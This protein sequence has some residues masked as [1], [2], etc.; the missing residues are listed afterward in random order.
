VAAPPTAGDESITVDDEG[1]F[2]GIPDGDIGDV[3]GEDI[4]K[5]GILP[6]T[7]GTFPIASYD[8]AVMDLQTDTIGQEDV[9]YHWNSTTNKLTAEI[10]SGSRI[11]QTLFQLQVNPTTGAYT[12]LLLLPVMHEVV[13]GENDATANLTFTVTDNDGTSDTGT[14]AITLNDDMPVD[15]AATPAILANTGGAIGS[16][17]LNF[18]GNSGADLPADVKFDSGLDGAAL[19]NAGGL[20]NLTYNGEDIIL[21]ID[22]TG[23][24]LTGVSAISSTLVLTVTLNPDA[25]SEGN[26]QYTIELH[27]LID[28]GSI[29]LGDVINATVGGGFSPWIA[30]NGAQDFDLLMYGFE[31]SGGSYLADS[32]NTNNG[33]VG[34]D[35]GQ[36]LYTNEGVRFDL[37]KSVV[38]VP[39]GN[40]QSIPASSTATGGDTFVHYTATSFTFAVDAGGGRDPDVSISLWRAD[41]D[42]TTYNDPDDVSVA[43]SRVEVNGVDV[44]TAYFTNGG[45]LIDLNDDDVVTVYTNDPAG[46]NAIEVINND[47]DGGTAQSDSFALYGFKAGGEIEG[48]PLAMSL[49]LIA[50]DADGDTSTGSIYA[51]LSP[52]GT[53]SGTAFADALIGDAD[54]NTINGL[55]G[56]DHITGG[57]GADIIDG[58]DDTDT[59]DYSQSS[60]AVTVNLGD[61]LAEVGGDAQ[62]DMLTSIEN[63][64]GTS[65]TDSL[66]GNGDDNVIAGGAGG[67]TINGAGGNDTADYSGSSGAVTVNLDDG[68]AETGGDA[69]GDVLTS[70]ENIIGSA[71]DDILI[72]DSNANTL[73]GGGGNDRITGND[74]MDTLIGGEGQDTFILDASALTTADIIDDYLISDDAVDLQALFDVNTA[75]GKD[76]ED[77]V[78]VAG[79]QLQVDT[80]GNASS[81]VT[82]ATLDTSLGVNILYDDNEGGS[83][84]SATIS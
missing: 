61:G 9:Q 79:N 14:F 64:I 17:S 33:T 53:L 70:I 49:D 60:G 42:A 16:G 76:I 27:Q 59:I 8:F 56:D 48:Q 2:A 19:T 28:N 35:Q 80:S 55:A 65:L 20:I 4:L 32:V 73:N 46:F 82:V 77:Y 69:Q 13:Q 18:F 3:T 67:D 74:G 26:D 7:S 47:Q 84:V 24:I 43:I 54:P 25:T 71:L 75:G 58:G 31:L 11:G 36:S 78:Q 51:E 38:A 62:G 30:T 66:T 37:V 72:G 5:T 68:L 50:T 23:H 83:C 40:N 39:I 81:W 29:D 6:G 21:S 10:T 44:T 15:F 34:V 63:I 41:E 1:L 45:V 57:A 12:F 22:A 52:T